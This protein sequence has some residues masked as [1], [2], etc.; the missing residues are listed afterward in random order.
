MKTGLLSL[1]VVALVAAPGEAQDKKKK[2]KRD[3]KDDVVGT[4]WAFKATKGTETE[5]GQFRVYLKDVFKGGDKV[6][7]VIPKDNDETTMV[8]DGFK[9]L[10]GK[11][12]LRRVG[13][14]PTVWR[15]VLLHAD[16]SKWDI[17]ID[18]KDK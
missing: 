4:I 13:R 11:V 2:R 18:V 6:G 14:N 12:V 8:I 1:I 5:R 3:G 7:V 17:V 15:G 9:K 10:N 16:G